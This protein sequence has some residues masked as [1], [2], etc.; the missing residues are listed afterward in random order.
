[1]VKIWR[2]GIL[3][4]ISIT[5]LVLTAGAFT[6]QEFTLIKSLNNIPGQ[7]VYSDKFGCAYVVTEKNTLTK[8]C[9]DSSKPRNYNVLRY[10]KISSVDVSNAL[11]I[12]VFYKDFA[13]IAVLD[14]T[15]SEQSIINLRKLNILQVGAVCLALD[16]NIWIYDEL[17]Y[18]L[19]K[20]NS[21]NNIIMKSEDFTIMFPESSRPDFMLEVENQLFVNDPENGIRVF[22]NFGTYSKTIPLKG[23]HKFEVVKDQIIYFQDGKL[24][25][26]HLKTLEN[27][28]I[29]LPPSETALRDV[30]IQEGILM[31][32]TEN[33][34]NLWAYK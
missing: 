3:R 14:N 34:L 7:A 10:G 32:L 31:C 28:T 25:S 17:E 26:F 19:K 11:K 6:A 18:R 24:Q 23:L 1:M 22:D 5:L 4:L 20:L 12:L 29:P 13:T 33:Q 9:P 15:L 21:E 2:S 8:F 16:N 30:N 27:K